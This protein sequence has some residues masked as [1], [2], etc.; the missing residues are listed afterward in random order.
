MSGSDPE[1]QPEL[2]RSHMHIITSPPDTV[3]AVRLSSE[4]VIRLLNK[5]PEASDPG[6]FAAVH[7]ESTSAVRHVNPGTWIAV[8]W[9]DGDCAGIIATIAAA[10]EDHNR[11]LSAFYQQRGCPDEP[12]PGPG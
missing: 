9:C 4:Q 1:D 3:S 5:H 2:R 11:K 8:T 12:G 10:A 6:F 7:G